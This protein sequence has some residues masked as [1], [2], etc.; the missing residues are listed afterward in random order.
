LKQYSTFAILKWYRQRN[1]PFRSVTVPTPALV[2]S[3]FRLIP[4]GVLDLI[5]HAPGTA[6]THIGGIFVEQPSWI[7]AGVTYRVPNTNTNLIT[8]IPSV[9]L[10]KFG[11]T[12]VNK[13]C[14]N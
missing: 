12:R 11:F 2:I 13:Y 1:Q 8:I 4:T 5:L 7:R 10:P 3:D 14:K 6:P 9:Y